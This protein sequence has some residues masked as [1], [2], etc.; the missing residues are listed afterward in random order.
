MLLIKINPIKEVCN[1]LLFFNHFPGA[2][3]KTKSQ[4][5]G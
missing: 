5:S 4:L 1:P 3:F 2:A